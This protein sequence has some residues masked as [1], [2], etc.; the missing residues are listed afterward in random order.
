M[1]E[2]SYTGESMPDT[3]MI[4]YYLSPTI[5]DAKKTLELGKSEASD[6]AISALESA[7]VAAKAKETL[8]KYQG[9]GYNNT[10]IVPIDRHDLIN[11]RVALLEAID[12]FV[13]ELK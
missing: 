4:A 6:D 13:E 10:T 7:I 5:A 1:K 8:F 3:T 9:Y 11:T 2:G 12:S